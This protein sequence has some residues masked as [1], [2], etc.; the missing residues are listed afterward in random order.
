MG[1]L[2]KKPTAKDM[3]RNPN[4]FSSPLKCRNYI[5]EDIK[6]AFKVFAMEFKESLTKEIKKPIYEHFIQ[7]KEE[8]Y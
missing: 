4:R 5:N 1:K 8:F 6:S 2:S 3:E 7:L